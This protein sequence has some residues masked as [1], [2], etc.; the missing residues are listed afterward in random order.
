[1][2]HFSPELVV[3]VAL[4]AVGLGSDGRRRKKGRGV[5]RVVKGEVHLSYNNFHKEKV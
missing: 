1:M 4:F 2:E 5:G 3:V